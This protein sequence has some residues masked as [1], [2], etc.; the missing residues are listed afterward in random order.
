ME[1]MKPTPN[2]CPNCSTSECPQ[3]GEKYPGVNLKEE[4]EKW[5]SSYERSTENLLERDL[6]NMELETKCH[7]LERKFEAAVELAVGSPH[8]RGDGPG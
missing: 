8:V 2:D 6:K 4:L 7:Q 3:C 5:K 1:E